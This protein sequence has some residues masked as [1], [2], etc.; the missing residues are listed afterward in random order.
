MMQK[1]FIFSVLL[2]FILIAPYNS[3]AQD[4]TNPFGSSSDPIEITADNL[5]IKRANEIAVFSGNVEAIQGEVNLR[6]DVMTVYYRNK[7]AG[8]TGQNSISKI[9]VD[10]NVFL[11]NPNETAQGSKGIYDVDNQQITLTGSVV[12]TQK[13]NV[14]KGSKLVY[15]MTTGK[16]ELFS[17]NSLGGNAGKAGRVRGIFVPENKE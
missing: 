15:D 13:D 9:D 16:S 8:E 11:T 1:A 3:F 14:V 6:S 10:G 17:E 5:T 7:K 4:G 12:L 2:T